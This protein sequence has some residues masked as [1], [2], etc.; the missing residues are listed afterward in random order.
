MSDEN[1]L[2]RVK[3]WLASSGFPLE[4]FTSEVFRKQGF[5][6][7]QG[8]YAR[9]PG[10][11]TLREID[12]QADA[13]F[14]LLNGDLLRISYLIE[15]KW[16][17]DKPW[18]IFTSADSSILP[19]A[20]IAHTIASGVS[21]AV[22]WLLAGEEEL[23]AA[24]TFASPARPGFGG[25]RVFTESGQDMTYKA[26]QSVVSASEAEAGSYDLYSIRR[27]YKSSGAHSVV[28]PTV[29]V[30][31]DLFE[32]FFDKEKGETD[33]T[34]VPNVRVHYRGAQK[35]GSITT[36]D[37]VS[38]D[39]LEDFARSRF[40]EIPLLY[41]HLQIGCNAVLESLDKRD[42]KCLELFKRAPRGVIGLPPILREVA[43]SMKKDT[44]NNQLSK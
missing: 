44:E 20:C 12:V 4:F 27:R 34:Q 25:S 35:R 28:F 21:E 8:H 11:E 42:L 13:N 16:S 39:G 37:I 7:H 24:A 10:E 31:G 19:S 5:S 36:I 18:V 40:L 30:D 33:I 32:A 41:K 15:C 3:E 2:K 43:K 17:R 14:K 26:L 29:V 9:E 23:A 38:K 22:L 1:L 6:V